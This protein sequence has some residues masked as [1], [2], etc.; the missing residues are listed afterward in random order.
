MIVYDPHAH[1]RRNYDEC[2]VLSRTSFAVDY[3][4]VRSL[5]EGRWFALHMPTGTSHKFEDL[6]EHIKTILE[7]RVSTALLIEKLMPTLSWIGDDLL[8]PDTSDEA[9]R[10]A[11]EE[12]KRNYGQTALD[13]A[14][15]FARHEGYGTDQIANALTCL[16]QVPS[17]KVILEGV[18]ITRISELVEDA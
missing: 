5:K 13:S 7:T 9:R 4:P 18:E 14:F 10:F 1:A 16:D 6:D 2:E 15:I 11:L 12:A 3:T 17:D 8:V